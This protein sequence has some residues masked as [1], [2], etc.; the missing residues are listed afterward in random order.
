MLPGRIS[1]QDGKAE[2]GGSYVNAID[3]QARSCD[4]DGIHRLRVLQEQQHM[5]T[6]TI[7]LSIIIITLNAENCIWF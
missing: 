4:A 5:Q 7:D 1:A 2:S 6:R 3:Q